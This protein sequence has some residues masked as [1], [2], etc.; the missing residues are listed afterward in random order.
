MVT[1][2]YFDDEQILVSGESFQILF[3]F[4]QVHNFKIVNV[5]MKFDFNVE[6][7]NLKN[8]KKNKTLNRRDTGCRF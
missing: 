2:L 1:A 4:N 8:D 3:A 7:P 6:K 5:S